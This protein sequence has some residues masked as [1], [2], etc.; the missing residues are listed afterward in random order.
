MSSIF[1]YQI[2]IEKICEDNNVSYEKSKKN[3][4]SKSNRPY[5][6]LEQINELYSA[7]IP[8]RTTVNHKFAF[9]TKRSQNKKSGFDYTKS[10]LVKND[11]VEKYIIGKGGISAKEFKVLQQNQH[12]LHRSYTSFLYD[13]FL[14]TFEKELSDLTEFDKRLLDFSTLGY[15]KNL[16]NEISIKNNK[17]VFSINELKNIKNQS[18]CNIQKNQSSHFKK[19]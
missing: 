11:L 16:L 6:L 13:I 17:K 8:I 14:P 4:L 5:Y 1:L 12:T 18:H 2:D 19:R 15:F 3:I 9:I 7:F 10:F